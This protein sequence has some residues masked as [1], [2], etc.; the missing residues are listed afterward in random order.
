MLNRAYRL[1]LGGDKTAHGDAEVMLL[2][3]FDFAQRQ[4][5][6]AWQ[7][8]TATTLALFYLRSGRTRDA[9]VV[10]EPTLKQ[11]KQGHDTRDV[12]AANNV[13]VALPN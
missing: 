3:S 13:L 8:R 7:L 5:A 10:L 4:D 1:L 6:K 12:Q 2:H 11:F 9:R